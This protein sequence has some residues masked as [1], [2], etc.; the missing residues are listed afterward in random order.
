MQIN[1]IV[2]DY[3]KQKS[4][5]TASANDAHTV[6]K[7]FNNHSRALALL[8]ECQKITLDH[9]LALL[10]PTIARWTAHYLALRRLTETAKPLRMCAMQHD[11][12][13]LD[14]AGPGKEK[15][16]EAEAILKL[17][18]DANFWKNVAMYVIS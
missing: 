16:A 4:L 1:L 12:I 14:C 3:L 8:H 17:V 18:N 5:L 9:P 2:G 11:D 7:W 15:V 6:I 10:I 13:L